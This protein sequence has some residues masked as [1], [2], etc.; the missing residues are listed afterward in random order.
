MRHNRRLHGEPQLASCYSCGAQLQGR[1]RYYC[2]DACKKTAWN[3]LILG[4]VPRADGRQ[5][6][7]GVSHHPEAPYCDARCPVCRRRPFYGTVNGE[8]RQWCACGDALTV[9]VI[10]RAA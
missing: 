10:R 2:S 4:C 8:L 5:E 9:P 6:H 1:Q 3:R 7:H